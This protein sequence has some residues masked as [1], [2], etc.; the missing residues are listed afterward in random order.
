MAPSG[1]TSSTDLRHGV[2]PGPHGG[3]G[4]DRRGVLQLALVEVDGH[5]AHAGEHLEELDGHVPE[6]AGADDHGPAAGT[7]LVDR[8]LDRV[9]RREA[10]VGQRH[11]HHRVEVADRHEVARAVDDE[12]V[13]H[14]PGAPRPG[15]AMPSSTARVQ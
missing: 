7:D 9:V 6:T 14:R 13:G 2:R 8:A 5:D 15:G 4:A 12:E 10:G 1:P 11:G 3:V